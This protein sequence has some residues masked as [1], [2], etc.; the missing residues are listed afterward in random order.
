MT[1]KK[2]SLILGALTSS[3]GIFVTKLLGIFYMVPFT[4]LAGEGNLDFI[5]M[6]MEFTRFC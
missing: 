4:A 2:Q 1:Q 3:A 5:L 6:L